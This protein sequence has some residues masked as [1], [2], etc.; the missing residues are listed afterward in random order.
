[1]KTPKADKQAETFFRSLLPEDSRIV[2]R[3]MFGQAS[4][5][6]NG[7]MFAGT[8]GE[9][10]FVRLSEEDGSVL[11]KEKGASF[12]SPMQGRQMKSYV[13]FPPSWA[14]EPAKARPWVIKSIEWVGT[15]PPKKKRS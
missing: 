6:L 4:A 3:P 1:M 11:M 12:F 9:Q 13:V 15:M 7:N 2:V 14:R 8:F 10:V 5:F